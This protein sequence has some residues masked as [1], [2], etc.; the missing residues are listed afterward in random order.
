MH[1]HYFSPAIP[2][3][4]DRQVRFAPHPQQ[5][6]QAD[7]TALSKGRVR[8]AVR[9]SRLTDTRIDEMRAARIMELPLDYIANEQFA[10]LRWRK[11]A[12]ILATLPESDTL[13]KKPR[14]P[15]GLPPYLASLYEVPLLTREQE[16]HLF[17]KMNYLKYRAS[18]LRAQLDVKQPKRGLMDRIDKLHDESLAIRNHLIQANLRLVVS[19]AKRRVGPAG[20]FL[21]LVS[22]GNMSLIKAVE[23]FDFAQGNKFSTYATWALI[24][25]FARTISETF[26]H[27]D[28]YCTSCPEIL[29]AIEDMRLH[30]DEQ[31]SAQVQQPPCL[32][33]LLGRL[34]QRER[35][36]LTRRFGLIRGQAPLMLKQVGTVLGVTK[37]R[38]RQIQSRAMSKLQKAAKEKYGEHRA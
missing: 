34:D 3:L 33:E 11:E 30:G 27:R 13:A 28:R 1:T 24:K 9:V 25:N 19:I 8:R 35:E 7:S 5:V 37:E 29:G 20:G 38:V 36:V 17:R 6:E 4:R 2:Q 14:A 22:D 31:D 16:V 21:E 26:R 23:K 18:V 15:G 32:E 10:S 12:E